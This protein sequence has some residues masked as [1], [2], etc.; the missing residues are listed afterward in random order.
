MSEPKSIILG[1]DFDGCICQHAKFP[2]V[3]IPVSGALEW[4]AKFKKL[5]AKQFLW[6]CRTGSYLDKA[7]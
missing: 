7:V 5:G 4:I 6:T 2:N 1:V 3:G